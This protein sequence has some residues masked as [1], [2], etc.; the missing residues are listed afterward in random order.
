MLRRVD[1]LDARVCV[2]RVNAVKAEKGREGREEDIAAA[3]GFGTSLFSYQKKVQPKVKKSLAY[4]TKQPYSL[5]R[6]V[7]LRFIF[8][9]I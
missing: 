4:A 2:F 6:L 9:K 1:C 7:Q 5:Q 3:A 8:R